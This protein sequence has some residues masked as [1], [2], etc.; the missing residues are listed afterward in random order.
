MTLPQ[1]FQYRPEE[2]SYCYHLNILIS[3]YNIAYALHMLGTNQFYQ[4][5]FWQL[6]AIF[7]A[8]DC[9]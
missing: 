6:A 4:I 2:A 3:G 1:I 5:I 8:I 7:K 9:I